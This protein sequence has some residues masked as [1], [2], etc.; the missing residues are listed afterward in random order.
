[1]NRP[2]TFLSRKFTNVF[3][4]F[5]FQTEAEPK[6]FEAIKRIYFIFICVVLGPLRERERERI[7][8]IKWLMRWNAEFLLKKIDI[9]NTQFSSA[10]NVRIYLRWNLIRDRKRLMQYTVQLSQ[11]TFNDCL[12][13]VCAILPPAARS[14]LRFACEM[15][16]WFSDLNPS[17]IWVIILY[18]Y[19]RNKFKMDL[20]YWEIWSGGQDCYFIHRPELS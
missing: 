3:E 9:W 14:R 10:W 2:L 13:L 19:L 8:W 1:M 5:S 17:K 15:Q 4:W 6:Y 11:C 20:S 12:V 18:D 7:Q 16:H